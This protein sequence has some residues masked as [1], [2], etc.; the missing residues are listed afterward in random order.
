IETAALRRSVER[1][2]LA[3][4]TAL[5]AAH[6]RLA[7]T[8][9]TD[10]QRPDEI[11]DEWMHVHNAFHQATMSGCA[12]PRLIEITAGLG[13]SAAIYRHWSQ[14]YDHGRRDIAGEHRAIFEAA[15]A[16]DADG[17][18]RLHAEHIGRTAEIVIAAATADTATSREP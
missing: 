1:G 13:E 12:S 5:V 11:T 14:R 10:P 15:L 8:P 7:G 6:H 3:W 18:C 9:M 17:A 4:E 16:R 2:D